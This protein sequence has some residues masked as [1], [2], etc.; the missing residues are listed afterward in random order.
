MRGRI[1]KMK[2]EDKKRFVSAMLHQILARFEDF[3]SNLGIIQENEYNNSIM[4]SPVVDTKKMTQ[5]HCQ[6]MQ[7]V[8]ND[9]SYMAD[10]LLEK[11]K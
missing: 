6:L 2:L 8:I 5:V 1:T 9:C 4:I 10:T 3:E 11:N 7:D